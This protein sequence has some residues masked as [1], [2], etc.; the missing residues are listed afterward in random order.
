M[1]LPEKPRQAIAGTAEHWGQKPSSS[2]VL[3]P[4][5]SVAI[6]AKA[7]QISGLETWAGKG[8]CTPSAPETW[9][10][11]GQ[12]HAPSPR[13]WHRY[14]SL[15]WLGGPEARVDFQSLLAARQVCDSWGT[16]H[17][18]S[19]TPVQHGPEMMSL[20]GELCLTLILCVC[21]CLYRDT[22]TN[23]P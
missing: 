22:H 10:F 15:N 16:W 6:K 9:D 4:V 7:G 14:R 20:C 3:L 1:Q 12:N 11:S 17:V 13:I 21:L 23:T 5:T 2:G 18:P 8:V 19:G